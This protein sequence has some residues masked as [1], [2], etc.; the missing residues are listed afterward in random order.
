ME[1]HYIQTAAIR[2][3]TLE[4]SYEQCKI[5]IFFFRGIFEVISFFR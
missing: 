1:F 5:V 4:V 2:D 3:Q